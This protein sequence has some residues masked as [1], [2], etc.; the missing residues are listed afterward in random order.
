MKF[1]LILLLLL[2]FNCKSK[3]ENKSTETPDLFKTDYSKLNPSDQNQKD[4]DVNTIDSIKPKSEKNVVRTS[5]DSIIIYTDSRD[6]IKYGKQQLD[7]ILLNYPELK[8]NQIQEPDFTYKNLGKE[9]KLKVHDDKPRFSSEAG[10]D[11][12]YILYS[13]FLKKKNGEEKYNH[14]RK[15]LI[16]IYEKINQV[17]SKLEHGGS[18]YRH[19]SWRIFGYTEYAIYL[20]E[21]NENTTTEYFHRKYNIEQQKKL[22]ITGLKQIIS[23]ETN[24]D[25]GVE[26]NYKLQRI[27]EISKIVNEIE[28]LITDFFYLRCAREFQIEY[29]K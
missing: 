27:K 6:T 22:F 11:E 7:T 20:F 23:D 29:Y 4:T 8:S 12:Y 10:Q 1:F 3:P 19:Q 18:Y 9:S 17:Y 25:G 26:N 13:Y 15:S 14:R 2:F 28:S 24:A 21:K 5:K 16:K